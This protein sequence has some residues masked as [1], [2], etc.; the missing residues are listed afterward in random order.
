MERKNL[1]ALLFVVFLIIS[2]FAG[3]FYQAALYFAVPRSEAY[4]LDCEMTQGTTISSSLHT[5]PRLSANHIYFGPSA[6]PFTI[7]VN[8]S[9][10]HFMNEDHSTVKDNAMD[11]VM[12][13]VYRNSN[14]SIVHL[15]KR[16]GMG[17]RASGGGDVGMNRAL[18]FFRCHIAGAKTKN[19]IFQ[20]RPMNNSTTSMGI[21]GE[22]PMFEPVEAVP[23][24]IGPLPMAP[25]IPER[26]V[27]HA[28]SAEEVLRDIE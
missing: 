17:S 5:M 16:T 3:R 4:V 22:M 28:T 2:F 13:K 14:T 7:A 27:L 20:P 12:A 15:D 26:Q 8:G 1:A 9:T 25:I 23:G 18:D 19:P 6:I 11:L 21:P 10:A 24:E